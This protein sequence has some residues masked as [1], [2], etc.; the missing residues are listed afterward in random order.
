MVFRKQ[1]SIAELI[2]ELP[3][4]ELV[5]RSRILIID[6]EKP[7]I[8]SDLSK[9]GFAVDYLEDVNSGNMDQV[10]RLTYDLILLDFG[11]VGNDFGNNEGLD[12]LRHI[13]RVAPSVVILTYTSKA[14]KTKHADFY[15][16]ADG[17]LAKDAG[18][19]DSLDRIEQGLRK[20]HTLHNTWDGLLS[21]IGVVVGSEQDKS[22]QNMFVRGLA[23]RRTL[24]EWKSR[25]LST[26]ANDP[27]KSIVTI[28]ISKL[29]ELGMKATFG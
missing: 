26:A 24:D 4:D 1:R 19:G 5:R 21:S 15:R 16:L 12:L 22:L 10:E 28:L 7:D 25:V 18:I 23:K 9:A 14:L 3:R 2:F 17:T 6:D 29:I 13:K 27:T 8:I 11:N 20:A